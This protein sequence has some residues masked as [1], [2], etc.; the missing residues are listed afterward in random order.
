YATASVG[1]VINAG[2]PAVQNCP[3]LGVPAPSDFANSAP[4][5]SAFEARFHS[6]PG[7]WSP[8]TF[9]SVNLLIQSAVKA[10]NLQQV[11]LARVLYSTRAFVGRTVPATIR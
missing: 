5:L 9:D 4:F 7:L 1:Y 2:L 8:Y 10:H 6:A 11:P 3:V